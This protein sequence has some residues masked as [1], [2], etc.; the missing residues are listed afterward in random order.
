MKPSIKREQKLY[1]ALK[2]IATKFGSVSYIRRNAESGFGLSED[3]ALEYSYE[4]MQDVARIAIKGM[5]R[6]VEKQP[7]PT[8][9]VPSPQPSNLDQTS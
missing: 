6:P 4:N 9:S 1:D 8:I 2:F 3:E 5:R 7:T